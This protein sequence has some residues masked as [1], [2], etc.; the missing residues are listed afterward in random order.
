MSRRLALAAIL[1][2]LVA[3]AYARVWDAGFIWD[4]DAHLTQNVCVV[5]PAGLKEI[6]TTAEAT[7]YPLVL[8]TFWALH[9]VVGLDPLPYHAA[10]VLF[11]LGSA[12]LLWR[13]LKELGIPGAW[14]AAAL[15]AIHPVMVQS[16]A[17]ITEM[18]NTQSCFFYLLCVLFFLKWNI[19]RTWWRFAG[20]LF[21]GAMA[22]ASKS[23]T[24]IL[25]AV[26][27][28]CLWWQNRRWKWSD[29]AALLPFALIS[30]A[31]SGWT[32]WEQK[33][34]SGAF[35]NEWAQ[36]TTERAIIAGR[37]VCFYL[38]KLAWPH[39][40]VFIYPHWQIDAADWLN[41]LPLAA[42]IVAIL[43]LWF[44]RK[45]RVRGVLFAFTYFV[46]ALLPV[47]GFFN[48]YF[49]RYS[50]VSDHFQYLA[51]IGPLALAGAGLK[52]A[53]EFF[54]P[55]K[56]PLLALLFG[57]LVFLTSE[58][59]RIYR[60][61]ETLWRSTLARNPECWMAHYELGRELRDRGQLDA[62]IAEY[63]QGLAI[64][65]DYA[66]AHY[67]LARIFLD[68]GEFERAIVEYQT[69]LKLKPHD[70]EAHN[71]LGSSYSVMGQMDRAITEFL[72]ALAIKPQYAEAEQNLGNALI[73]RGRTD[74]GLQHLHRAAELAGDD[75]VAHGR[76]A[77]ALVRAGRTPE[78]V[79]EF[80]RA[81]NTGPRDVAARSSLAWILATAPDASLREGARALQLAQE[82]EQLS[83]G[84]DPL[85][86][87]AL[88]AAY[89]ESGR[90]AEA[91]DAAK[92]ALALANA[93][94]NHALADA[95]QTE[96]ALYELGLPYRTR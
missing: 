37:D 5:G 95:L 79:A 48:V 32:I 55:I 38:G 93:E 68:R 81:I 53:G 66:D 57:G 96:I 91:G 44:L 27:A 11:H 86:L 16:V 82:A 12:L 59:T 23:S 84:R 45:T 17:W 9:K 89:A 29:L 65:P 56:I 71:N 72:T 25:P 69:V 43:L 92:R 54:P 70:A 62:A 83:G 85:A 49:F 42:T 6:W 74:D 24:V 46:V 8:T 26:L 40:L 52:K 94:N 3:A 90:F 64:W 50:F 36:T 60:N 30:T 15:W 80:E 63:E 87:H 19:T 10:N 35:G 13:A 76:L 73:Q 75:P 22:M 34:H 47:L 77:T 41:Y 18:K 2:L 20:A 28:L 67:N 31:V 78:A 58:Q 4:D 39:P 61:V 14:I 7:Y 21:F 51:S 33:F 1:I 88:A